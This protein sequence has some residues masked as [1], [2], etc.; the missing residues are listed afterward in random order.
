VKIAVLNNSAPF[1]RGGAEYLA[2]SLVSELGRRGHE[3][4]LVKVPLRWS[5]PRV[6]AESMIAAASIRIPEA[7]R[8]IALKFPAYLVPHPDKVVW[9]LHQFRQAYDL[10]DTA[11]SNLSQGEDAEALRRAIYKADARA[12]TEASR[13]LCNSAVTNDRLRRFNGVEA[14]VLLAPH[15]DLARYRPTG[16]G[17]Y[18]VAVGRVNGAKRQYLLA[19]AMAQVSAPIRLVIAGAPESP[20]DLAHIEEIVRSNHLDS[21][22]DVIARYISEDEKAELINGSR[23][24]AYLPYDEDSYGYVTAEAMT[25]GK[26]VITCTDSGGI[27]ELVQ[28]GRTGLVVAPTPTDLA[29]AINRIGRSHRLAESLGEAARKRVAQLGLSWDAAIERLLA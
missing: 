17:D 4:E 11:G 25:A 24:V 20:A 9:L 22:V 18:I 2:D 6:V 14:S 15:R 8:I 21:R 23:A 5:S 27:L 10:W 3:V 1:L 16:Y 7:D 19:E 29:D 12:F 13:V 26:A 28:H